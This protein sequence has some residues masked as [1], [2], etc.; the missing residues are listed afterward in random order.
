MTELINLPQLEIEIKFYLGQTAQNIIEVGKRLIAA[1]ALV[2]HGHWQHWL[3]QNFQLS[4]QTA[5]KFMKCSERFANAVSMRD[6]Q[7]TQMITLLSL[8]DAEETEKFI[9]E[10]AAEGK[11][12]DEMTI[13]QLREEIAEYKKTIEQKDKDF[14]QSLFNL[15]AENKKVLDEQKE[16]YQQQLANLKKE[17]KDRPTVEPSDYKDT[18]QEL[19]DAQVTIRELKRDAKLQADNFKAQSDKK[20]KVIKKL[21]EIVDAKENIAAQVADN[22]IKP[23]LCVGNGINFQP[24][25]PYKLLLTDPPYSNLSTDGEELLQMALVSTID[26]FDF[27][28][29][30]PSQSKHTGKNQHGQAQFLIVKWDDFKRK[31]TLMTIKPEVEPNCWLI[32]WQGSKKNY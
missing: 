6:L 28:Q 11:K 26:L 10:K 8:P 23:I 19:V 20:D 12:V 5:Q 17:L 25:A 9:A 7:S 3:E 32:E 1:K 22:S 16:K 29:K 18:K 30:F 2:Q 4:Q 24:D 13:K 14:Q 15:G 31:Y 27:I 21:K